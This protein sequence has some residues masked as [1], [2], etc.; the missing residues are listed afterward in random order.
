MPNGPT[1]VADGAPNPEG[2]SLN[3]D[4]TVTDKVTGL[5]W[6]QQ[7]MTQGQTSPPVYVTLTFSNANGTYCQS[8]SLGGYS[9]W[10]LPSLIEL[11]SIVDYSIGSPGPVF[12]TVA[13][14]GPAGLFW[15]TTTDSPQIYVV[16]F[17][18]GSTNF[19]GTVSDSSGRAY[20]RCVR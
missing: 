11:E 19:Y 1:D 16:D 18:S 10:R 8:L 15:S 7:T 4:G 5:M 20:A 2:Y 12:N 13:F 14:G 17:T 9:D 6:Q 3:G